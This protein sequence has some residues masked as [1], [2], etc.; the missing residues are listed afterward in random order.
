MIER[1]VDG[2]HSFRC[3][4][5]VRTRTSAATAPLD[6]WRGPCSWGARPGPGGANKGLDRAADQARLRPAGRVRSR[7][8]ATPSVGSRRRPPTCTSMASGTGTRPSR[9]STGSRRIARVSIRAKRSTKR[10]VVG[11]ATRRAI[12]ASSHGCIRCRPGPGR[13]CGRAEARLVVLPPD[14][15]HA[16]GDE[17]SEALK[18][19]RQIL[20][21]KGTSPRTYRNALVFLAADRTRLEDLEHA[22]RKKLAWKSIA[23]EWEALGLDAFQ[24]N[25]AE[26]QRDRAEEAVRA[27]MPETFVWTLV[28]K[29]RA[30]DREAAAAGPP[31]SNGKRSGYRAP[32]PLLGVSRSAS[33]TTISSSPSSRGPC[34]GCTSIRCRSGEATTSGSGSCPTFRAI[35]LSPPPTRRGRPGRCRPGR[36]QP[37]QLESRRHSH[38]LTHTTNRPAGMWASGLAM[39]AA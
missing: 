16:R 21:S 24:K 19:A 1:D 23:A 25:Q 13:R 12:A 38:T 32:I 31:E 3:S 15:P 35:S 30:P 10:S 28:P 4:R 36:D 18:A 39:R 22:V 11:C 37:A 5:I 17:S 26:T 34:C 27:Q 14:R 2:P 9:A 20:D 7:R 6:A 29:V 33:A 8:S